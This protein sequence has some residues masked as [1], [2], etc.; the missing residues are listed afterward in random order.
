MMSLTSCCALSRRAFA[1]SSRIVRLALSSIKMFASASLEAAAVRLGKSRSPKNPSRTFCKFTRERA[2]QALNKLLT[3]HFQ[4]ENADR[5]FFVDR[6]VLGNVHR[7]RS[8]SH[9]RPRRDYDHFRSVHSAR[10][11]IEFD[12][13]GRDSGDAAFTLIK[14]FDRLDRFHHLVLHRKHLAFEPV[15]ADGEN[16]LFYFVEKVSDLVLFF[17]SATNALGGGGD[18]GAQNVFVP[19]D[20]EVVTDVRGGRHEGEETR[21]QRRAADC[22]EQIPIAQH[23]G[24]RDQIDRL[25]GVPKIDKDRVD[26][27]VRGNVEVFL[28]N[29]LNDFG[30]RVPRR[31]QHRAEHALLGFHA[32]RRCAVNILRRTCWRS[33]KNSSAVSSRPASAGP[34]ARI[35][36]RLLTRPR[37]RW[38]SRHLF[39]FFF[40][41]EKRTVFFLRLLGSGFGRRAGSLHRFYI[42]FK[43]RGHVMM[44]LD[45]NFVF[46]GVLDRP[47]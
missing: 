10:H 15:F 6:H 46:A 30:D 28:V 33:G 34:I 45:R 14:F 16:F 36:A 40:S 7:Q 38:L 31:D 2:K 1:R 43:L 5:K 17:V 4:T 21:Y 29:F 41:S 22:F 39:C 3:A 42:K 18:N 9:A 24:E 47:L 8:F 12:K 37:G 32:V 20:L 11:P 26:S 13:A 35:F 23:L 44:E 25:A 27:L 19:D